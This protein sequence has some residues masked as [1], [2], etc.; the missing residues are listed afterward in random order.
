VVSGRHVWELFWDVDKALFNELTDLLD[1]SFV[2]H[3]FADHLD[4]DVVNRLISRG[5]LVVV[6]SGMENLCLNGVIGFERGE[7]RDLY[8]LGQDEMSIRVE[9]FGGSYRGANAADLDMRIYKMAIQEKLNILHLG[10]HDYRKMAGFRGGAFNPVKVKDVHLLITPVPC[11]DNEQEINSFLGFINQIDP[12]VIIP[13]HLAE[14]GQK[15]REIRGSYQKAYEILDRTGKDYETLV[16]GDSVKIS[17]MEPE[18]KK[19]GK[20]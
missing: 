11:T 17:F 10:E 6:P 9:S 3:R 2:T 5:K 18:V 13:S 8:S 19:E 16:W 1:I 14:L 4:L 7:K 20:S 15:D 12:D